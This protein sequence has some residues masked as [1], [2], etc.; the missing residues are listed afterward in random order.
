MLMLLKMAVLCPLAGLFG[1]P[2][3]AR[4]LFTLSLAQ[5]GEFG[6]FLLALR[7]ARPACCRRR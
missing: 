3:A 5:A 1:L 2:G 6:F 7:A 4:L